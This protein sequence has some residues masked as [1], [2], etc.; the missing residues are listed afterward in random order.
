MDYTDRKAAT[1]LHPGDIVAW[2]G[3]WLRLVVVRKG[4][5]IVSADTL[6][7]YGKAAGHYAGTIDLPSDALVVVR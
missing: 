4:R 6:N 5:L 3:R 7:A 2:G 1:D